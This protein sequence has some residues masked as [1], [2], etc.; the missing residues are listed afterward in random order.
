MDD[1][2]NIARAKIPEEHLPGN[3]LLIKKS[4]L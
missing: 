1:N 4:Q 3:K 2:D